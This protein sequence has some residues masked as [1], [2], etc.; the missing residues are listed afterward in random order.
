M[1]RKPIGVFV[2]LSSGEQWQYSR[3]RT[4][5]DAL[6]VA[7]TLRTEVPSLGRGAMPLLPRWRVWIAPALVL[8]GDRAESQPALPGDVGAVRDVEIT[9]PA[10]ADVSFT[11]T[12]PIGGGAS[13]Q[14]KLF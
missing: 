4:L 11:L 2:L 3:E 8:G 9:A 10:L 5:C 1:N 12:A 14:S 13:K 7:R 6:I